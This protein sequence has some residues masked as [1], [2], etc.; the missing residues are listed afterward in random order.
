MPTCGQP[1]P[2]TTPE[3]SPLFRS[4]REVTAVPVKP[5]SHR[6]S[7]QTAKSPLF[8]TTTTSPLVEEVDR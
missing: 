6:C 2:A 7:G 4:N 1:G 8:R 3:L 5:R